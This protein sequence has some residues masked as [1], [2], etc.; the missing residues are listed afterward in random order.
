MRANRI[1]IP[2]FAALAI[3]ALTFAGRPL[4]AQSAAITLCRV[5][6]TVRNQNQ[7]PI[8][9]VKVQL[10]PTAGGQ[11]YSTST[12]TSGRYCVR[13]VAPGSYAVSAT[14]F[15][16]VMNKL[17]NGATPT[18]TVTGNPAPVTLDITM[19]VAMQAI[20][21][22]NGS[23]IASIA[24][25]TTAIHLP[26]P[27]TPLP[28]EAAHL[29]AQA[30]QKDAA[31][32]DVGE[33]E[34]KWF[35]Q[36]KTGAIQYNV[37]QQMTLGQPSS[38]AVTIFGYQAPVPAATDPQQQTA[39]LKV[40]NFMR[41]TISQDDNPDEFTIAH[42]Q[43]ADEQFVPV[44]GTASWTWT[45]TPKHLGKSLKLRLQAF[46]LYSDPKQGIQQS[47]PAAS[48]EVTVVAEGV[49]GIVSNA[50]DSFWSDPSIWIKYMLP[51]GAGFAALA[52]VIGWWIKRKKPDAAP[53]DASKK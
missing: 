1:A 3:L 28:T 37:P 44:S 32:E 10:S 8:M 36:L 42:G 26:P 52:A 24:P 49:K 33:A 21:S 23:K 14:R 15:G 41:V 39:P 40:S 38:V 43:N 9:D 20:E 34:A 53:K 30:E 5:T 22:L 2:I 7:Q 47:F 6:G 11:I 27:P 19:R 25:P 35:D 29:P 16:L 50:R 45:V 48:K 51:G 46:V 17:A 12:D 13:G 31:P 18:V 4:A